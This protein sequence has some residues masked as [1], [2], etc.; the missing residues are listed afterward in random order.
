MPVR[1]GARHRPP[2]GL[3]VLG[4]VALCAMLSGC[5]SYSPREVG[6]MSAY[7]LC[8]AQLYSRINLTAETRARVS[9]ETQRRKEDC[10]RQ[11]PAIEADRELEVHR[12]MYENSGP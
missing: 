5:I 8:E 12:A 6:A 9:E 4:A 2:D 3:L 11:R 10:S 7:D 1:T